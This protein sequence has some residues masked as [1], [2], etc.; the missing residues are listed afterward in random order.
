MK[1]GWYG[2]GTEIT[3]KN[4]KGVCKIC[5]LLADCL[6]RNRL[7]YTSLIHILEKIEN[8]DLFTDLEFEMGDEHRFFLM[9]SHRFDSARKQREIASSTS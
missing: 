3:D 4:M 7:Q 5:G 2:E 1:F 6:F 8:F 9:D